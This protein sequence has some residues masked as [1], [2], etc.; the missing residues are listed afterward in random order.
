[1]YLEIYSILHDIHD[2]RKYENMAIEKIFNP[3]LLQTN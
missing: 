2:R 3:K 1:M